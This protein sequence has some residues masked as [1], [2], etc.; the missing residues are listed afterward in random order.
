MTRLPP[1]CPSS[2]LSVSSTTLRQPPP[3]TRPA[4]HRWGVRHLSASAPL[5]NSAQSGSSSQPSRFPGGFGGGAGGAGG[6]WGSFSSGAARSPAGSLANGGLLPHEREAREQTA[7]AAPPE[8][9][10]MPTPAAPRGHMNI[11]GGFRRGPAEAQIGG[12]GGTW[13]SFSSGAA[14]SPAGSLANGGLLLLPHEREARKQ[15]AVAAP[16]APPPI[17]MP[18]APRGEIFNN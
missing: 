18:A 13:G 5:C 2:F 17:P 10:P 16:P 7:V 15:T 4:P 8:P 1:S 12:A 11:R 14:R 9:P 6:T 3:V